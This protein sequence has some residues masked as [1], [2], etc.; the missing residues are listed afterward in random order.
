M[1]KCAY[2]KVRTVGTLSLAK[3]SDWKEPQCLNRF[4]YNEAKQRK[5]ESRGFW[6][7]DDLS[8]ALFKKALV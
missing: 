1:V 7:L 2:W 3:G 5:G 6:I 4:R 8:K